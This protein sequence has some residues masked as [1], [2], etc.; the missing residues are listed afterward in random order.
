[1]FG[2]TLLRA[3]E[4]AGIGVLTLT[5][6]VEKEEL[7]RSR[8]TRH[9]VCNQLFTLSTCLAQLPPNLR[10]AMPEL[11]WSGWQATS[12]LLGTEQGP[13]RHE[14]MWFAIASLVPATLMWL[15]AYRV[16]QPE[17]FNFSV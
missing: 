1:M 13:E 5:E 15:R 14:V 2:A 12:R 11:D 16:N 10:V 17:L 6:G 8:L 4:E 3:I 7:L 9:E